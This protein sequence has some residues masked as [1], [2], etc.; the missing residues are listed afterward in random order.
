MKP[1]TI[2]KRLVNPVLS[3]YG[4]PYIGGN[5]YTACFA[6]AAKT[7]ATRKVHIDFTDIGMEFLLWDATLGGFYLNDFTDDTDIF[8]RYKYYSVEEFEQKVERIVHI[9]VERAFPLL[10][11]VSPVYVVETPEMYSLLSN[12]TIEQATA[13]ASEYG[14]P[15]DCGEDSLQAVENILVELRGPDIERRKDVFYSNVKKLIGAA[16]Y[17][18]ETKRR[19]C[20]ND[21]WDWSDKTRVR[22][23]DGATANHRTYEVLDDGISGFDPL[24]RVAWFWN[25]YPDIRRAGL[26]KRVFGP[27]ADCLAGGG[28][29][30]EQEGDMY[31][32]FH[33]KRI[34]LDKITVKQP[35]SVVGAEVYAIVPAKRGCGVGEGGNGGDCKGRGESG[36]DAASLLDALV[37]KLNRRAGA[38]FCPVRK[39]TSL[40]LS[41]KKLR[42]APDEKKAV[43]A[44]SDFGKEAGVVYFDIIPRRSRK[45]PAGGEPSRE[46]P[47]PPAGA[48]VLHEP[49]H[50]LFLIREL[51]R[52]P[53]ERI[54]PGE[55][56]LPPDTPLDA[57]MYD[58]QIDWLNAI[59][60]AYFVYQGHAF[61]A[62][63]YRDKRLLCR[64]AGPIESPELI[65]GEAFD[66]L[67]HDIVAHGKESGWAEFSR[68]SWPDAVAD[69]GGEVP[70][71]A[72]PPEL[73]AA[74]LAVVEMI[75]S[76][77]KKQPPVLP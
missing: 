26:A 51:Y 43:M 71:R 9:L 23:I 53:T 2:V 62:L 40:Q 32:V 77:G 73:A 34:D 60:A 50:P 52:V 39:G 47:L 54:P 72:A 58:D 12:K 6:D 30:N 36:A 21:Y 14:L 76:L 24:F 17:V 8:G 10:A 75:L 33:K 59:N 44:F 16:A 38:V 49:L 22:I 63:Q 67:R 25:F 41:E 13:F 35:K 46:K 4:L 20:K 27:Q 29:E 42:Y 57:V 48:E 11:C 70:A 74:Q 68:M 65:V 7:G 31:S 45:T 56:I 69:G 66:L 55:A 28:A 3:E 61:T 1:Q 5:H 18:G 15:A 64:D 37:E 19:S